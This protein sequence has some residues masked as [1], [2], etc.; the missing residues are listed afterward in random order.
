M[1]EPAD[2][3]TIRPVRV[4]DAEAIWRIAREAGVIE[5]ILALPS[6]RL[7]QRRTQLSEL[8]PDEHYIVA[9][10]GGAVAGV[11]GLQ[12]GRGR[13]RHSGHLFVYVAR[14]HQARAASAPG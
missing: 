9:E 1:S 12:V 10:V 3:V 11:A 13:L 7:E 5:N 4:E 6:D 14:G 8:G 2:D